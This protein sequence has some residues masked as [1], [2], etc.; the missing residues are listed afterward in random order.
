M[1]KLVIHKVISEQKNLFD[2][3]WRVTSD[4]QDKYLSIFKWLTKWFGGLVRKAQLRNAGYRKKLLD[5]LKQSDIFNSTKFIFPPDPETDLSKMYLLQFRD[6]W[7]IPWE[8]LLN[9]L[10]IPACQNTSIIRV[11]DYDTLTDGIYSIGHKLKT[12]ILVGSDGDTATGQIDLNEETKEIKEVVDGL[13]FAVKSKIEVRQ[14]SLDLSTLPE[15]LQT[16]QPHI[17]WFN[18]HGETRE[19]TVLLDANRKWVS[20]SAIT[21]NLL[22]SNAAPLYIILSACNTA[23]TPLDRK[24]YYTSPAFFQKISSH[25]SLTLLV[26]QSPIRLAAGKFLAREIFKSILSGLSLERSFSTIRASL[27]HE[28]TSGNA[29]LFETDWAAP[30]IWTNRH[31]KSEIQWDQVLG[32]VEELQ[33]LSLRGVVNPQESNI[34]DSVIYGDDKDEFEMLFPKQRID[35]WIDLQRL[36]LTVDDYTKDLRNKIYRLIAEMIIRYEKTP[37]L[38]DLHEL[39][40]GEGI[41]DRLTEELR[42]WAVSFT[43]RLNVVNTGN[44]A[45]IGLVRSFANSGN[46]P[47]RWEMLCNMKDIFLVI[48]HPPPPIKDESNWFWQALDK[49]NIHNQIWIVSDQKDIIMENVAFSVDTPL[50]P[51]GV[52]SIELGIKENGRLIKT[53]ALLNFEI[54]YNLIRLSPLPTGQDFNKKSY[55]IQLFQDTC[56]GPLIKWHARNLVLD[57]IS[58]DERTDLHTACMNLLESKVTKE[59]ARFQPG[60]WEKMRY[61]ALE[62]GLF[63]K[64]ATVSDDLI[65]YYHIQHLPLH[66]IAASVNIPPEHFSNQIILLIAWAYLQ[67][68]DLEISRFY[69]DRI[70]EDNDLENPFLRAHKCLLLA[71]II[72]S[73]VETDIPDQTKQML[74]KGIAILKTVQQNGEVDERRR[75]NREILKFEHDKLRVIQYLEYDLHTAEAGYRWL[76]T[77]WSDEYE[78]TQVNK[79]VI[80]RNLAEC[81]RKSVASLY[82]TDAFPADIGN[83]EMVSFINQSIKI[84]EES[85][86]RS[87]FYVEALY[88]RT[89]LWLSL[90]KWTGIPNFRESGK[91]DIEKGI[92]ICGEEGYSML[93]NILQAKYL[94]TFSILNEPDAISIIAQ[95]KGIS[96]GWAVRTRLSLMDRLNDL[97]FKSDEGGN[98]NVKISDLSGE[99]LRVFDEYRYVGFGESDKVIIIKT[100][101]RMEIISRSQKTDQT[102]TY[103][104]TLKEKY[105][106]VN[107]SFKKVHV[108]TAQQFYQ[109][110]LNQQ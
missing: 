32:Q 28:C 51:P 36:L 78:T 4:K 83:H 73:S 74:D 5:C 11:Q 2:G 30:V 109:K 15:I 55:W 49:P 77:E 66:I 6:Y 53:L 43:K 75:A 9:D 72:K 79:A 98:S 69:L 25:I 81:L 85:M 67:T 13:P 8:L 47:L 82:K 95:L 110:I 31:P 80:L 37:I 61:H 63:D 41:S 71:E 68:G 102:S 27:K 34:A 14:E 23:Q 21:Q 33:L 44:K 17:I 29:S 3:G 84:C 22:T 42:K 24:C 1:E 26:M 103:E 89:K 45:L 35:S 59:Y 97:Y 38:I 107:E 7:Q 108:D 54:S 99:M 48:L 100:Y 96:H 10:D 58:S 105:S 88:E 50:Q 86:P 76:L 90:S 101:G 57:L 16:F 70:D 87:T 20:A 18:G 104:I 62:A 91:T 19:D 64:A 40:Y 56:R 39:H 52:Q 94:V 60:L 46:V 93:M 106:W 65:T 12:L 92:S